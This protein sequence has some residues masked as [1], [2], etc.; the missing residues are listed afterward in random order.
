MFVETVA[1]DRAEGAVRD[2]YD[3][4]R[5]DMGHVPNFVRAFSH[6]PAVLGAWEVLLTEIRSGMDFR[7][8]EIATLGAARALTSSYCML[9]HGT[10]LMREEGL[11]EDGLAALVGAGGGP[12]PAERA[13][14]AFAGKVARDATSVTAAD[15]AGLRAHG[16]SDT[17]IFDVAATA[18][19]R[20]FISK[21]SDAMGAQPDA[22]YLGL[23]ESLRAA[24]VVGRPIAEE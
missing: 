3:A 13:I 23:G 11:G 21:M 10:K 8:Y 6:R 12:D 18:A 24:L 20:C 14:F 22:H 5:A 7:R 16:L 4:I 9:A 1:E 17:E 19:V 15:V 2:L